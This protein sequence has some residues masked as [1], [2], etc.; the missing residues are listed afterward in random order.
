MLA[1]S[2][3]PAGH[4]RWTLRLLANQMVEL[5]YVEAISHVTVGEILKKHKHL[6]LPME[7]QQTIV[8]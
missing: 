5:A 7:S 2:N 1:G 6:Y 3:P 8:R 4:V